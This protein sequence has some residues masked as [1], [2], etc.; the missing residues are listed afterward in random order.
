MTEEGERKGRA[1]LEKEAKI[2]SL[3]EEIRIKEEEKLE[4]INRHNLIHSSEMEQL[5]LK[6]KDLNTQ[7]QL[8]KAKNEAE[9]I[10][11]K[12]M[13]KALETQVENNAKSLIRE[14][15]K[16]EMQ[17]ERERKQSMIQLDKEREQ[18]AV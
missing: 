5:Q 1:I 18:H 17:L 13:T 2:S 9:I 3:G 16:H 6:F 15:E 11:F 8:M 12:S 14:W 10:E 7:N 4:E